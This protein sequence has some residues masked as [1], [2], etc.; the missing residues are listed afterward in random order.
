MTRSPYAHE[1]HFGVRL[2]QTVDFGRSTGYSRGG[3]VERPPDLSAGLKGGGE[4]LL[5][6]PGSKVE[7]PPDLSA[8]LKEGEYPPLDLTTIR[9]KTARPVRRIKG[10]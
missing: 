2:S 4:Q 9:R 5:S 6:G 8:G 1:W 10:R 3:A 7:R